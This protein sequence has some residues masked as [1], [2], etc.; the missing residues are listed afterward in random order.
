VL[1]GLT[2]ERVRET[3]WGKPVGAALAGVVAGPGLLGLA[4]L[5]GPKVKLAAVFLIVA[6]QLGL[7]TGMVRVALATENPFGRAMLL[8]SSGSVVAG[9]VLAATWALGE[10]PLQPFVD[11]GGMERYHGALNAIGFGICG[12]IG[13]MNSG[14]G[15]EAATA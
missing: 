9:M 15:K 14:Q 11:L 1:A 10:Y 4:F 12:L 2:F 6:G 8:L 13:W 7:A 5:I 3:Q